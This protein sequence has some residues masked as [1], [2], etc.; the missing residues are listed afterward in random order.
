[1]QVIVSIQHFI[2]FIFITPVSR[3]WT[4]LNRLLQISPGRVVILPVNNQVP[5]QG[6]RL[7]PLRGLRPGE[8]I[9]STAPQDLLH[10]FC[11]EEELDC[12]DM[13]PVFL[14]HSDEQLYW[15]YDTHL[16]PQG[17][18]LIAET[19]AQH[20]LGTSPALE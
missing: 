1:M 19:I 7:K 15:V 3:V 10:D 14:A 6:E 4:R 8:V 9:D 11:E 18:A 2:P 20:I 5:G 17:H 16:T 12:I 13:L